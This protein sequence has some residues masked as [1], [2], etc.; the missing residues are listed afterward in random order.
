[1]VG[2]MVVLVTAVVGFV[3]FRDANRQDP[4][5]PVTEVEYTQAADYARKQASFE[6]LVPAS[7]PEGWRATTVEYVPGTN[8]RWH[9]GLL[10]DQDRYVGLEQADTS[11][12]TMVE[13]YVDAQATEGAPVQVEGE[14]WSTYSDSGGDLAL[15][16]R[17]GGV[18]TL[19]VG[20]D[21]S[22]EELV[23]FTA[24]LR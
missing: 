21:V 5:S 11:V 8:D 20:H 16:R 12:G 22:R 4:Q 6:V 13:T 23:A 9:L 14:P 24:S 3:V 18:T 17:Q 7:L 19:V 2:A 15:V 10:T 1:L